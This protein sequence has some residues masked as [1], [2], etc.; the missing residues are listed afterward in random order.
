MVCLTRTSRY[1]SKR[2]SWLV[3]LI[4]T[5]LLGVEANRQDMGNP[6]YHSM[7]CRN[8]ASGLWYRGPP[9]FALKDIIGT[10][11]PK[12]IFPASRRLNTK[13]P[14][15]AAEYSRLLEEKTI[16]QCLIERV[17]KAHVSSRSRRSF[18]KRL[19][20]LDKELGNYMRYAEKH[21]RKIKSGRIPFFPEASLWI[22]QTQVYPSLLR[23]H[24]GK[25]RNR[26]NLNQTARRCSIPDAFSLSIQEIYFRL[27]VCTS[28]CKY[29]RKNGKYYRRKHLFNCLDIAKE[30]EYE[31]A[32][33]QILAIIQ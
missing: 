22:C 7:Q 5:V 23:Y 13:L 30:K 9:A 32:A 11:P 31:E 20:G 10:N 1:R 33:K 14:C 2:R 24:A 18:T 17:R 27:K 6:Q 3:P 28:K 4:P 8:N 12:I 15:I 29:F 26:G 21:C 19:N 25:V 16:K